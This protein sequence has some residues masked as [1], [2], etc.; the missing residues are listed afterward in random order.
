MANF[1]YLALLRSICLLFSLQGYFGLVMEASLP[2]LNDWAMRIMQSGQISLEI[3]VDGE[4]DKITGHVISK[5]LF[6][7]SYK[8]GFEILDKLK[9]LQH[10]LFKA[11]RFV[12]VPGSR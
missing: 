2:I 10:A 1:K 5:L 8:K 9:V 6:G 12:G 7:S 11:T 4:L 3:E